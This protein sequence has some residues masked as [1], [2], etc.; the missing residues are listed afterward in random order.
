MSDIKMISGASD[1]PKRLSEYAMDCRSRASSASIVNE[2]VEEITRLRDW[3]RFIMLNCEADDAREFSG[4]AIRGDYVPHGFGLGKYL[5]DGEARLLSA[6]RDADNWDDWVLFVNIGFCMT[7]AR[8][9]ER[10]GLV[11][12]SEQLGMPAARLTRT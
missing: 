10:H 12:L 2:A 1:L 5:T 9:L 7:D 4:A 8:G 3:L 11:Q 6:L